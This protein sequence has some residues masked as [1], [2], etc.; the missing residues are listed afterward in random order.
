MC[1]TVPGAEIVVYSGATV[2]GLTLSSGGTEIFVFSG[3]HF[4]PAIAMHGAPLSG[5]SD[6]PVAGANP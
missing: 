6:T 4:S 2:S 3:G 5:M 1:S